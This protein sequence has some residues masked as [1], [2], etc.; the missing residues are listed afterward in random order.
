M[1]LC[2]GRARAQIGVCIRE[3]DIHTVFSGL[4]GGNPVLEL[5]EK[6]VQREIVSNMLDCDQP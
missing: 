4:V 6:I 1:N 3:L 2:G 5:L